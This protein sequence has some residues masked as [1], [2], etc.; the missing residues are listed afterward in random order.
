M[1]L[2]ELKQTLGANPSTEQ[3][4]AFNRLCLLGKESV[5][6]EE[7][8]AVLE[9]GARTKQTARMTQ[10]P[11]SHLGKPRWQLATGYQRTSAPAT[12]GEPFYCEYNTKNHRPCT[13][14]KGHGDNDE[15]CERNG[16]GNCVLTK[17]AKKERRK[18]QKKLQLEKEKPGKQPFQYTEEQVQNI[19]A[20]THAT[21]SEKMKR[22]MA[23]SRGQK[24]IA[25]KAVR[26][27][28]HKKRA[29][30]DEEMIKMTKK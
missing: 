14:I 26:M 23:S 12:G 29:P 19:V 22:T 8:Q 20:E 10:K 4:A 25:N 17:E 28:A 16:R 11:D 18:E 7:A 30:A 13:K 9:G 1:H 2:R 15:H 24:Q 3:R 6:A 5:S 27:L 21:A